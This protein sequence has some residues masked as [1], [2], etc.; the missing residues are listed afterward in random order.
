[1][2]DNILR[3]IL[4]LT[5][6]PSHYYRWLIREL[7][8]HNLHGGLQGEYS[9]KD[10]TLSLYGMKLGLDLGENSFWELYLDQEQPFT[11]NMLSGESGN[12]YGRI[13]C[14]NLPMD[15]LNP[16]F[17]P[18]TKFIF[19][20]GVVDGM[21]DIRFGDW[22]KEI[23]F[24]SSLRGK[25]VTFDIGGNDFSIQ[26]FEMRGESF[27]KNK[28]RYFEIKDIQTILLKN[29]IPCVKSNVYALLKNHD[30]FESVFSFR[31][32]DLNEHSLEI[33]YPDI[34]KIISL[35]NVRGTGSLDLYCK[36][37]YQDTRLR[38]E[39]KI[40]QGSAGNPA[41]PEDFSAHLEGRIVYGYRSTPESLL[42]DES[43]VMLWQPDGQILF[44]LSGSDAVPFLSRTSEP[45]A[46]CELSSQGIDLDFLRILFLTGTAEQMD[47]TAGSAGSNSGED[48]SLLQSVR[49]YLA[50]PETLFSRKD[51]ASAEKDME[52]LSFQ[53]NGNPPEIKKLP[54]DSVE[55][56]DRKPIFV[57]DN[58][59]SRIRK[60][61]PSLNETLDPAMQPSPPDEPEQIRQKRTVCWPVKYEPAPCTWK[62][63][64]TGMTL[65]LYNLF[66]KD[67][68]H[69]DLIGSAHWKDGD[70]TVDVPNSYLNEEP[71]TLQGKIGLY[72]ENGYPYQCHLDISS[73]DLQPFIRSSL[74]EDGQQTRESGGI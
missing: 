27:F 47:K 44:H 22:R 64:E 28:F 53:T 63:Q 46:A 30:D 71:F 6:L 34:L 5:G 42:L 19:T 72:E 67:L 73:L 60:Y 10:R 31:F 15:L 45:A 25:D 61:I 74:P 20:R 37:F 1:M 23:A 9:M 39:W 62:S 14:R 11:L 49:R 17:G 70:F 33:L 48:I 36:K 43:E 35:R 7:S 65:K 24:D 21:M 8:W 2:D 13:I 55:N 4:L 3:K 32:S 40:L 66:Y 38:S 56:D 54:M 68:W 51:P 18:N 57:R 26:E 58:S 41:E 59:I 16:F 69:L 12:F 52:K 50:R 29:K